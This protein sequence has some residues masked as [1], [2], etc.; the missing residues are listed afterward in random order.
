MI[1]NQRYYQHDSTGLC[2]SKNT[3]G[4]GGSFFKVFKEGKGRTSELY[5][6]VDKNG[7]FIYPN[8]KYKGPVG[9]IVECK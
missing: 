9:K 8:K 6:D 4:H 3:A 2:R 1:G 7:D 5:R